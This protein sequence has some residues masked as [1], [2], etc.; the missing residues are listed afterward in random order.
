MSV[1]R[2]VS[3]FRRSAERF[4]EEE[5]RDDGDHAERESHHDG[6]PQHARDLGQCELFE[7]RC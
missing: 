4:A 3:G 1:C 5:S 2:D 6:P 7:E